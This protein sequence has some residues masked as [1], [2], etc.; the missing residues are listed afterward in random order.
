MTRYTADAVAMARYLVEQLPAGADEVFAR[1][2]RG[3]DVIEAPTVT[4]SETIWTAVNKDS[5]GRA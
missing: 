1:A 5:Y 3:V 2:E 4:V